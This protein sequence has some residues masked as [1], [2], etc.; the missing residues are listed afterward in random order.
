LAFLSVSHQDISIDHSE[1]KKFRRIR[2]PE[3][4][5]TLQAAANNKDGP[6]NNNSSN[7]NSNNNNKGINQN[8]KDEMDFRS[9]K[10]KKKRNPNELIDAF[11]CVVT[12]RDNQSGKSAVQ[13]RPQR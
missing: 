7:S 9:N 3:A 13:H 4:R 10:K 8:I 11:Y 12:Y 5:R 2:T 1:K 6:N